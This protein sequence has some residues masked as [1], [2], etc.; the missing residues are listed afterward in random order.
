MLGREITALCAGWT[1]DTPFP[2]ASRSEHILLALILLKTS[3]YL[4]CDVLSITLTALRSQELFLA[5][6]LHRIHLGIQ[7]Q[8]SALSRCA[9]NP[10]TTR[11]AGARAGQ[12]AAV[13]SWSGW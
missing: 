8:L 9:I 4:L 10:V 11:S 5:P 6:H 13:V 2:R 7:A 3:L 12:C 1:S